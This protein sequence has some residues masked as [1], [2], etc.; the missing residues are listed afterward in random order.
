MWLDKEERDGLMVW[1]LLGRTG[2]SVLILNK[3]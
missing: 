1:V 2:I 3:F